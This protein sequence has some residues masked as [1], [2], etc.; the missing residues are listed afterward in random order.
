MDSTFYETLILVNCD[1][2]FFEVGV[3]LS[4]AQK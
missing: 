3:L 4:L 1:N 2:I